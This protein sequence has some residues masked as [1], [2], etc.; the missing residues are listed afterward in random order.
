MRKH[1]VAILVTLGAI[2]LFVWMAMHMSFKEVAVPTAL[3]GEAIRNPFYAA[4]KFSEALG[5]EAAWERVF[6]VPAEDSVIVLSSWNWTLSRTRRE[7][8]ERWVESGGRLVVDASLIG[9]LAGFERWSGIGALKAS[10]KSQDEEEEV[11]D[12][13]D[14]PPALLESFM[15]RECTALTE[16]GTRRELKVC[17]VNPTQSLTSARKIQWALRDDEKIEALRTQVGR[18]SVT[19]LNATPFR[20]RDFF[21]GDH[22]TLFVSVT[23]L[24]R[25]DAILLFTEEDHASLLTLVWRFGAPV[26]LLLIAAIALALWRATARFGP[27]TAPAETARRSLAEQIRGTGQFALRFGGGRSLHAAQVRALRDAVIRHLP[28]FDRMSSEERIA[29]LATLSSIAGEELAP[30]LNYSGT[31]SSHELRNAIAI[32]ETARRRIMMKGN[33]SKG[34]GSKNGN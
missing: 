3:K 2:A 26:V 23:Q 20:R 24:H 22:P 16:D 9:D 21:L 14:D 33:S 5:A 10:G 4:V 12:S 34:K 28:A 18:G 11:E 30:A 6:T 7:R 13:G 19:V 32:I 29:A 27:P 25:G 17:G 31:R 8:I 15:S 1:W